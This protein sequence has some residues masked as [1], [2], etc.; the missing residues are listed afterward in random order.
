MNR[1]MFMEKV[2]NGFCSKCGPVEIH[3]LD[4]ITVIY[5]D[6]ANKNPVVSVD[7]EYCHTKY[8]APCKWIDAVSFDFAGARVKGFSFAHGPLL[9]EE[10]IEKFMVNFNNEME[11][12]LDASKPE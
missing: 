10:E 12:F 1:I 8:F 9:E 5:P 6:G 2:G 3:R 7:C 4:S 11:E